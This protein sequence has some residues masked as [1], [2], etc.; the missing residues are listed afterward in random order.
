VPGIP[1]FGGIVLNGPYGINPEAVQWMWRMEGGYGKIVWLPTFDADNHVKTFKDAPEAIKVVDGQGK[2]LP[3]V[4]EVMKVCA[5]QNLVL[6]TGHASASESLALIRQAK[7]VGVKHVVVTHAMFTVVNMTVEQMKEAASLGAKL[8]LD[9]LGTL[10]GP[11]AHMGWMTHWKNVSIKDNAAAI[12]A[13][14]AEHFVMGT[15]L[16]QTG[17]PSPVDGLKAMV[18]GLKAEGITDAQIR[19]IARDNAATMLGL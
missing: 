15:D 2:V 13:V 7:D 14:G 1:I 9:H 11:N 16:G 8:E 5:K 12:K 6:C 19:T 4:I 3:A 17:N 10:M 18:S